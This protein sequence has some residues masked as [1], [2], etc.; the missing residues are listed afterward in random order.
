MAK[1]GKKVKFNSNNLLFSNKMR[2]DQILLDFFDHFKKEYLE[3]DNKTNHSLIKN[4]DPSFNIAFY[5]TMKHC[6]DEKTDLINKFTSLNYAVLIQDNDVKS[7]MNSFSILNI[8]DSLETVLIN[9]I[10][11]EYPTLIIV[12]QENLKKYKIKT[13][14]EDIN[15][16]KRNGNDRLEEGSLEKNGPKRLKVDSINQAPI[17]ING[18]SQI[19]ERILN[20]IKKDVE[21]EIEEG[22]LD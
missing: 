20:E 14:L 9:K 16:I 19:K 6:F 21:D 10:I 15:N 8:N 4:D 13:N 1:D 3:I 5:S 7:E 22:E 11:I 18:K 2:L 12:D 17:E